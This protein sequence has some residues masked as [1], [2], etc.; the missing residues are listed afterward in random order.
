MKTLLC[1][2]LC[3][4]AITAMEA[5]A[6]TP[7]SGI[8]LKYLDRSVRP[9]DNFYQYVNGGWLATTEIP[10]DRSRYGVFDKLG[11]DAL[12]QLRGI[13][14]GLSQGAAPADPER[15]KIADLYSTFMDEAA[16]EQQGL[17]PLAA[18]F[19]RIDAIRTKKQ[20]PDLIAHFNQIGVTA[21]ITPDVEQDAKD[22]TRYV[23]ALYQDGLGMPNRDYYL[24]N[25]ERLKQA[26]DEYGKYIEK[27]LTLA[28]DSNAPAKAR[29]ILALETALAKVQWTEVENR[30]PVKTYNR[31]VIAE[32]PR[33]ASG[34]DWQAY[35]VATGVDGKADSLVITQPS[36]I[37]GFNAILART[38]LA[39]WK[40]YFRWRMLD[41][42]APY[43]S[44]AFVAANFAFH[45]TVLRGAPENRPRWKR[46]VT[47]L[48]ISLG[49]ALGKLYVAKYFPPES[50]AR[51]DE[52]VKNVLAAYK[53]DINTLGW[54]SPAT[55]Q[56]AQAKLAKFTP[57]IG[58]PD[59]WRDYSA[60]KIVK[61]DLIGNVLRANEFEYRRNLNKLGKPVDR[62][63]WSMTP[64]TVNAYYSQRMNKIVFPAA[65]LQPPFFNAK[66]DDAVNYGGIGAVI[67][68][69]ISHGFDDKGSQYD[70]DGNLVGTP[71]WFTQADYDAFRAKTHALVMQYAAQEPVP[72]YHVNGEL[73]L[74]E[75]IADNSGLAIAYKAYELSLGGK[76]APVIDG[77]TGEQ[78]FYMSWAQVWRG[79]GR[80]GDSVVRIKTDPHS[81]AKVRGTVTLMNQTAFY[82]AFGIKPG[83]KM[84]L[85][86]Q[87]RVNLW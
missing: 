53:A 51:A 4:M 60:L 61:G 18:E 77:F 57:Q 83:D 46:G 66:A 32:L 36:Y 68:H 49:E 67:G 6:A 16:L 75:N 76:P 2:A 25:D 13:V 41:D 37:S 78:R 47:L 20:I 14:E 56:K 48:G 72:G 42:S 70:G 65:I 8:D 73:T 28:G 29:D 33:L 79:K 30:D 15:R 10:A 45:G 87:K 54:M 69:E 34:Y 35:L 81:P 9:Q 62:N 71:G 59:K 27:M 44:S 82:R 7:V 85:D 3:L 64:Q 39:T 5:G 55:R 19:A 26:R 50:K 63:E 86:P 12:D 38:P 31:V 11:D 84:Y 80:D 23:F 40:T 24:L 74:G 17:Q 1:E 21:P 58:Y 22:S 43:L 52:L